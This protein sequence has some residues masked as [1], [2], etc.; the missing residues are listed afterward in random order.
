MAHVQTELPLFETYCRHRRPLLEFEGQS[1]DQIT[2]D[3]EPLLLPSG[4]EL[5]QHKRIAIRT[6]FVHFIRFVSAKG[7]FSLL[8]ETWSLDQDRWAGATI[9]ATID[10]Q[11]QQ[12]NLYHHPAKADYC[13]LITLFDYP[14]AE[15]VVPLDLVYT[16]T[17]SSI[18][19]SV[20]LFGS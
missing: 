4:F 6:G 11:A 2:P 18:W 12:L 9:R 15:E 5:H 8:N 13:Q 17:R 3:F 1:A 16:K 10:T 7:T 14:L 20:K 19:P